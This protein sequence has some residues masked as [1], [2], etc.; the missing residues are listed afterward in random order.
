MAA[1]TSPLSFVTCARITL[2]SGQTSSPHHVWRAQRRTRP[3][4]SETAQA[5]RTGSISALH[6]PRLSGLSAFIKMCGCRRDGIDA[7]QN[8]SMK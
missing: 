8:N 1:G 3:S 6:G 7:S 2:R 4:Q 5:P